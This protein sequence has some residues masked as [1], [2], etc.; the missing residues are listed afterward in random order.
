M[1]ATLDDIARKTGYHRTTVSKVLSGDK[2]CYASAKTRQAIEAAAAELAYVP[3]YFARSLK[4]GRSQSI[5]V[6][7][8]LDASGIAGRLFRS[9]LTGL[10]GHGYLPL[11]FECMEASQDDA[12]GRGDLQRALREAVDRKVDG[13]ILIGDSNQAPLLRLFPDN[14]PV[15]AVRSL[16]SPE[17]PCVV[18]DRTEAFASGVRWLFERGHRRI[19]FQGVDNA[20]AARNPTNSHTLKIEGYRRE[21][22]RLG[23]EDESLLLDAPSA[24]GAVRVSVAER[25][26][27]FASIS[28]VLACSDRVAAEVMSGLADCGLRVPEGCS[29]VGFD[30]AEFGM[31]LRPRLTTFQ[32]RREEVGAAAVEMLL[33]RIQGEPVENVIVIPQLVERESVKDLGAAAVAGK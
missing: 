4:M 19:A 11:V 33:R 15:V 30:D 25:R 21:M 23:L 10:R 3:N 20:A 24:Y 5:G 7:G 2:R 22:R 9:L 12:P 26:A 18:A 27:H 16:A 31:A 32:P 1:A 29:V 28:A 13:V 6:V 17:L 14:L 8:S